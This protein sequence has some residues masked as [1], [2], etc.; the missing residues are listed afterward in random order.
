MKALLVS[1]IAKKMSCLIFAFPVH[2]TFFFSLNLL[3]ILSD[4]RREQKI[5]L[6]LVI[7]RMVFYPDTTLSLTWRE[8]LSINPSVNPSIPE[9]KPTK[10]LR[11]NE[12]GSVVWL[13]ACVAESVGNGRYACQWGFLLIQEDLAQVEYMYL[14]FTRMPGES[15]LCGCIPCYTFAVCRALLTISGCCFYTKRS[16]PHSVSDYKLFLR[17]C[18][19]LHRCCTMAAGGLRPRQLTLINE[20]KHS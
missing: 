10:D 5:K 1:V 2:S 20:Q 7:L 4:V 13:H 16:R 8:I 14:V 19:T 6:L 12:N 11:L 9:G 15:G 3:S 18:C 17:C